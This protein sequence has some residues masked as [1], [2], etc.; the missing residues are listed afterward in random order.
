MTLEQRGDSN[1]Q[2]SEF[3][4]GSWENEVGQHLA[5]VILLYLVEREIAAF[6]EFIQSL[7]SALNVPPPLGIESV[8]HTP[9]SSSCLLIPENSAQTSPTM[10][11]FLDSPTR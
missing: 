1:E 7:S 8:S 2:N 6:L 11:A 9:L 10:K 4:L 5:S 3:V